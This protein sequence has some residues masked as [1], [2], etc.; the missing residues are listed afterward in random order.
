MKTTN[1]DQYSGKQQY[2][3]HA[4]AATIQRSVELKKIA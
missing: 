4:D 3:P 1:S 2:Q